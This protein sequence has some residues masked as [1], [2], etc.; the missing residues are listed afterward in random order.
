[1]IQMMIQS[2]GSLTDLAGHVTTQKPNPLCPLCKA[3]IKDYIVVCNP[4]FLNTQF[5]GIYVSFLELTLPARVRRSVRTTQQNSAPL[6]P[7]KRTS[8]E[9]LLQL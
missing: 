1:M 6:Y 5:K 2:Y 8:T 3:E 7:R 9:G 4:G